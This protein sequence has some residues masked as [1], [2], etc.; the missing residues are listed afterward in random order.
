M[1]IVYFVNK[2]SVIV[3][4]I[5]AVTIVLWKSHDPLMCRTL[6]TVLA[7][8]YLAGIIFSESILIARTMALWGYDRTVVFFLATGFL[9]IVACVLFTV[10]E[11][12]PWVAVPSYGALQSAGCGQTVQDADV[13]PAYAAL[14]LGDTAIVMLTFLRRFL[15]PDFGG[16]R[17]SRCV[18]VRTM[19][20]DGLFSYIV[21]LVLSLTNLSVMIFA[22]RGLT[23]LIQMPLRVV[24]SALCTRVLLNLRRAAAESTSAMSLSMDAYADQTTL[25]FE[26]SRSS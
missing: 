13:W 19:Y 17:T 9:E 23:P 18:L 1:K 3:D 8:V 25:V 20:R 15:D 2:Y 12:A 26:S 21:I 4:A 10:H 7:H 6:Y 5:L 22:P 14:M 24:H 16:T 11:T